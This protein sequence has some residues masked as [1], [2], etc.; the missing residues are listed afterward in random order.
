MAFALER[1]RED[2]WEMTGKMMAHM[3]Q[4]Q[5]HEP[6]AGCPGTTFVVSGAGA[7]STELKGDH[8]VKFEKTDIA[9]FFWIH[10]KDNQISVEA[11]DEDGVSEWTWSGSK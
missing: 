1:R 4:R 7:K 11:I 2:L 6:F 9:G 3:P 8:P 5:W 10:L